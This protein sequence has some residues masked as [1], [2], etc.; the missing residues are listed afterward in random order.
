MALLAL[1]FSVALTVART[2]NDAPREDRFLTGKLLVAK[3][4]MPDPRFRDTVIFMVRHDGDGA[5]GLVVN[6]PLGRVKFA[7]LIAAMG[8]DAAGVDGEV[9][10]FYG[11]PVEPKRGFVLHSLDRPATPSIPVNERYGVSMSPDF[12]RAMASGTGPA[13]SILAV[14]YAGWG[15]GQLEAELTRKDWVIAPPTDAILFDTDF[16]SKW[17]RAFDSRFIDI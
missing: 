11:G 10:I 16:K 6:R 9:A 12:L 4:S 15:K 7:E 1:A 2:G 14:G 13:R 8:V 17:K 5:L 3:P